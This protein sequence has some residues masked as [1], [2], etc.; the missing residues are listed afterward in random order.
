M[1]DVDLVLLSNCGR[2]P[3]AIDTGAAEP[4]A[5]L[6]MPEAEVNVENGSPPAAHVA[7]VQS[8]NVSC[9]VS[10]VSVSEKPA[11][12]SPRVIGIFGSGPFFPIRP[13]ET[14]VSQAARRC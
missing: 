2:A 6:A 7:E 8:S 11:L 10:F 14:A 13:P 12:S 1:Q 5:P 9:P 3:G 4:F